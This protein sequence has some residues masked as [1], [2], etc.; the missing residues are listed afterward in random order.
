MLAASS[1]KPVD[2]SAVQRTQRLLLEEQHL[3]ACPACLGEFD[4]RT[5]TFVC[6][7]CSRSY[8][9]NEAGIPLL[10]CPN[11]SSSGKRDVTETVKAF[12]EE[13]PFP[14]YDDMDS[15]ESLME[16]ANRGAF[17][18]ALW[19]QIPA[20]AR[21]LEAGCGTGQL[22]NF[23]GMSWKRRV[24]GADMCL[25][26]LQLANDFRARFEIA[27]AGFLQMNLFRPPFRTN[28]FDVVIC[29]GVLHHT[30]DPL[31]GFRSLLRVVKPGG[32]VLIGLY[33][34]IGRLTTDLRRLLFRISKDRLAVLDGHVRSSRYNAARKR[35]WYN[36]QYKNPHETKHCISEVLRWFEQEQVE[37]LCSIPKID[38]SIF[39]HTEPLFEPHPK[40]SALTRFTTEVELL[41]RGGPDGALFIMIGRKRREGA[42]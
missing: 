30:G 25:H 9:C 14:N 37:F 2:P 19:D 5:D 41:L 11:D 40:G 6:R 17:A 10:F 32:Y 39:R 12:Y 24:L 29:N 22:T 13:T 34:H 7:S 28:A 3:L 35:A 38:G 21:V 36:D 1:P 20:A 16:K 4:V 18:R 33:N 8:P 23:L 27:N 26:S 31:G 42:H 15:R